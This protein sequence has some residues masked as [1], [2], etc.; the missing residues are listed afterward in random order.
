[1]YGEEY[2]ERQMETYTY[3]FDRKGGKSIHLVQK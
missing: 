2:L 3:I 1:M